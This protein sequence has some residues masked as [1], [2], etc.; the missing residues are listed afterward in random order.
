MCPEK[1]GGLAS[2]QLRKKAKELPQRLLFP[3]VSLGGRACMSF[4][5]VS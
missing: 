4:S 2:G 5:V 3:E 1:P